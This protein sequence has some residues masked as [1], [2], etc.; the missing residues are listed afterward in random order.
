MTKFKESL[1]SLGYFWPQEKPANRWPGR[2]FIDQFPRARLHCMNGRPGDGAPPLG[3]L[4][5]HGLTESNEYV[6]MLE[7]SGQFG[8]AS[9]NNQSATESIAITA[10]YMLVG[11]RHF[12]AGPSVRRLSFS[13][14]VVEHVLRLWAPDYKD[15]RHR[16]VGS[17]KHETPILQKQVASYV[18]LVRRI[19]VRVFRSRVPTTTINPMS[20]LMI[21]FLDLATPK[22]ALHALHEFRSFLTLICGYSIDLWDVQ[23]LHKIGAGY[24]GS[25]IYFCDLI[26]R[27]L[28]SDHF[29]M[30]P[31]L[32]I[33]RDRELFRRVIAGW[34][35]E[36]P[37]RKI[38][39]GAFASIQQDK[40]IL[41]LSHLREL[42]TIIEMQAGSDGT[43]PLSKEKSR[44]LRS[45]L[46]ATLEAFAAKDTD[47][48]NWFE[49]IKQRIDNI[50]YHEAKVKV[51][52]FMSQLPIGFVSVPSTFHSDVVELRHKL[53]HDISRLKSA[54]YNRLGFYV[55]KLKALYAL[56]DAIALGGRAEEI[57]DRSAFL[58]EAE[59]M[60]LDLFGDNSADDSD[61][62]L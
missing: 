62:D 61:E 44:A 12:E 23:L 33:C 20:S 53:V 30:V 60:P 21:D 43:T 48:Q 51:K 4:T 31:I 38:G 59:H 14:S 5:V 25:D 27:P 58:F 26:E 47:S 32:D 28:K 42:V 3:R 55:A 2:V 54:D 49:T 9:F 37:A 56:Y 7:A 18:D 8:G 15:I 13:S 16:R 36:P 17:T 57:I 22:Q 24:Q 45:A 10:N 34:L 41:H 46:R 6:T 19:R 52:R 50:N 39:R 40:G 35:A 11:S 1:S 29:P